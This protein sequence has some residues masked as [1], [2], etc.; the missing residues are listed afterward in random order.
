M[1]SKLHEFFCRNTVQST[2]IDSKQ[3]CQPQFFGSDLH[4]FFGEISIF[5][6]EMTTTC[7]LSQAT[8]FV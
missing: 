8:F 1:K 7:Q 4:I 6:S 5:F 2:I 3:S